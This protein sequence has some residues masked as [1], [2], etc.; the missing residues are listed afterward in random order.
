MLNLDQWPLV[1]LEY[2][3]NVADEH[4]TQIGTE[5]EAVLARGERFSMV[6]D[7][8]RTMSLTPKQRRLIV[9]TID[10]LSND[11]KRLCVGQALV[12]KSAMARGAVT[13][14]MWL[15]EPPVPLKVFDTHEAANAWA[16]Q[17]IA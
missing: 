3:E 7:G 16:R 1:R 15:R 2:P 13:A 4:M 10:R 5:L 6:I 12:V 17:L 14:L 11:M 8:S 9:D